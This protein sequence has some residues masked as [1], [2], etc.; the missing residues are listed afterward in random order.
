LIV[1]FRVE[2]GFGAEIQEL[3][4]AHR[5]ACGRQARLPAAARVNLRYEGQICIE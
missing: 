2:I 1:F 5:P 4:K 3:S